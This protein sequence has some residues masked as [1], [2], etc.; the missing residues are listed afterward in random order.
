MY[1][2]IPFLYQKWGESIAII[3]ILFLIADGIFHTVF[4]I[5]VCV[6]VFPKRQYRHNNTTNETMGETKVFTHTLGLEVGTFEGAATGSRALY[7]SL[8]T[9]RFM[10]KSLVWLISGMSSIYKIK[11]EIK[12]HVK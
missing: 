7:F 1:L 10:G 8:F 3:L 4:H 2:I 6:W 12:L 11:K 9:S 5:P